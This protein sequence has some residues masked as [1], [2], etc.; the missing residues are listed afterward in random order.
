M[1]GADI[2]GFVAAVGSAAA[3]LAAT[4]LSRR[5]FKRVSSQEQRQLEPSLEDRLDELTKTMRRS[6][7]LLGAIST[8]LE[9]QRAEVDRLQ[10]DKH[11]AE[12]IIKLTSDQVAAIR[13]Q[14]AEVVRPETARGIKWS[15]VIGVLGFVAGAL[16]AVAVALF[17]HPIG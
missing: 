11:D 10:K 17:V 8:E 7:Q 4:T 12:E 9:L 14:V 2:A 15:I 3:G 1:A 5:A 6:A 13:A 16:A